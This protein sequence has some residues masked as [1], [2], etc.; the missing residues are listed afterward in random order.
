MSSLPVEEWKTASFQEWQPSPPPTE[1]RD[2]SGSASEELFTDV[3]EGVSSPLIPIQSS[4]TM[5]SRATAAFT[6]S[7]ADDDCSTTDD[8]SHRDD[9]RG[10]G[11]RRHINPKLKV[12]CL[13]GLP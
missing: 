12:T 10:A 11:D 7:G 9:G 4:S 5:R 3:E 2:G 13:G 1:E 8:E 6:R